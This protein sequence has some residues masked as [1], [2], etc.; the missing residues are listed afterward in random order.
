MWLAPHLGAALG[1]PAYIDEFVKDKVDN[2]CAE[3]DKLSSI[4]KTQPH[5]AYAAYTHGMTSKWTYLARTIPDISHHYQRLERIIRTSLIPSLMNGQPPNDQLH[6]LLGLPAR[7]GGIGVPNPAMMTDFEFAASLQI[8]E[9][10]KR[11]VLVQE[12]TY[13]YE[14]MAEQMSA[15]SEI[16]KK[17]RKNASQMAEELSQSLPPNLQ[18][19]IDLAKEKGASSWLT[20]LP[21]K[22]FGFCLHKGAFSDALA[23][24]YGLPLSRLPSHCACGRSF[25][26]EHAL[27][28]SRGGFPII[29][30]NEVRDLTASLLTEVCHDVRVEPDLQPVTGEMMTGSTSNTNDGARLDIAVNGFWGGRFEKTYMD[31]RVFNPHAPSNRN[32]SI[33]QCYRKHEQEKKRSYDQRIREIEHASFTPLV[34]S[35]TGGLAKQA[36]VFYKRLASLLASKWDQQYEKTLSWLRCKLCYCLLRSAIQCIRG[37]RSSRGHA[38]SSTPPIDLVIEESQVN[39]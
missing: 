7:L 5:A 36:E 33:A 32:T 13:T 24:R 10:L 3:L 35:A 2:W 34:L 12:P 29:R 8:T 25:T 38:V 39:H 22:E 14:A 19:A 31:V 28:C 26:V 15:I 9:P 4:A 1:T 16:R 30:H 21:I 11:L 27:S 20:T 17:R 37:A 6:N 18:R 23:P